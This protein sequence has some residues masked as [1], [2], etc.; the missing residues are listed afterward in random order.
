MV[1]ASLPLRTGGRRGG[2]ESFRAGARRKSAHAH[3]HAVGYVD[4]IPLIR[5]VHK[6]RA[7]RAGA[8]RHAHRQRGGVHAVV[9]VARRA[10]GRRGREVVVV[11]RLVHQAPHHAGR[12]RA[13]LLLHARIDKTARGEER[14][15]G[16]GVVGGAPN[17]VKGTAEPRAQRAQQGKR[18]HAGRA[19]GRVRVTGQRRGGERESSGADEGSHP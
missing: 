15:R 18:A 1:S 19:R 11:K 6:Q 8:V 7:I 17:V 9:H 5:A 2:V 3:G 4:P 12:A 16:G 10:A 13:K 14:H